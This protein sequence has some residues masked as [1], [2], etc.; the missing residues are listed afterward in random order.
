MERNFIPEMK[1]IRN[2]CRTE[3]CPPLL[4]GLLYTDNSPYIY[5]ENKQGGTNEAEEKI[6]F[7]KKKDRHLSTI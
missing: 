2:D 1:D 3:K 7:L 4:Q 6:Q 5:I